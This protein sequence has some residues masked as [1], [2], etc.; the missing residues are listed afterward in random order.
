[1]NLSACFAMQNSGDPRD[2]AAILTGLEIGRGGGGG[3]QRQDA[4]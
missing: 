1:M 4:E 3:G 2:T